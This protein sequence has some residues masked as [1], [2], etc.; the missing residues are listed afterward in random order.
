M[1]WDTDPPYRHGR[2]ARTAV[3]LVNLGTPEAPTAAAVRPYLAQFLGDP[4]VVELPRLVWKPLLRGVILPLRAS[5]SA[6]KYASI[7]TSA[8]S[9]LKVWTAT[10]AKLL[11]GYLGARGW[12]VEVAYAMRYGAPSIAA[13]LAELQA[14]G[15]ERILVLP[16]FPQYSGTTT[17]SVFDAVFDACTR[18]RN[19]PELRLV[20]HYHDHP[21]YIGA[22]ADALRTHFEAHGR[23]R[24]LVFS[25]HGVPRRTLELG[26][27]YHCEC[28][29]TARLVA[30][31]LGLG[32]EDH[33]VTFQS[34]FGKAQWL[35]PYTAP[36]L[37]AL[38]RRGVERVDVI[39]PGFTADCLETLEE[40]GIEA[41]R[42]FLAAGGKVFHYVPCLNDRA[43]WIHALA[44]LCETH[45]AGGWMPRLADRESGQAQ[46]VAS[47]ARAQAAGAV[48]LE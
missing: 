14:R 30:E 45:G 21:G 33:L 26:D 19:M 6:A 17:A 4:R 43:P 37:E 2:L 35:E 32:T 12:D 36:T 7:W 25:F 8:G 23:A 38:A 27:P 48:N 20:K 1:R 34:R 15:A 31:A 42:S 24:K 29:K 10:Q 22:L 3:L 47:R 46:A 5:K 41:K 44:D 18:L 40:I 13:T 9:P 16:L 28:R 11:G 39:C